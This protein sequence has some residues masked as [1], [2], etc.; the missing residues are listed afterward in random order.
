M[1]TKTT[2]P[3][4]ALSFTVDIRR[5]EDGSAQVQALFEENAQD[6]SA[7]NRWHAAQDACSTMLRHGLG[8]DYS[9]MSAVREPGGARLEKL[10][11]W[12]LALLDERLAANS[13]N[14][15]TSPTYAVIVD[16]VVQNTTLEHYAKEHFGLDEWLEAKPVEVHEDLLVGDPCY[17]EDKD[18]VHVTA[19]VQGRWLSAMRLKTGDG[20][21]GYD[22]RCWSLVARHESFPAENLGQENLFEEEGNAG[23][24]S[25]QLGICL[26]SAYAGLN[27]EPVYDVICEMTCGTKGKSLLEGTGWFAS[28]GYGDG[29]YRVM[30]AR[31]AQGQAL[32]ISIE[33]IS[34]E[35][36]DDRS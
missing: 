25:G 14:L 3:A 2:S 9:R 8:D 13:R 31:N 18:A 22:L 27:D 12:C 32:A 36:P 26:A 7:C 17:G 5:N 19:P 24:D 29:G 34:E 35:S 23:V 6:V 20:F 28:S 15:D 16:G 4:P 21:F 10:E 33:F 30:V 11:L 1:T